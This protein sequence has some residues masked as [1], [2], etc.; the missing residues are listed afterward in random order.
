[1]PN[2]GRV[3]RARSAELTL[4]LWEIKK[5]HPGF[6]VGFDFSSQRSCPVSSRRCTA[7]CTAGPA[8]TQQ[9]CP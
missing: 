5:S 9:P 4:T 7:D 1:M 6:G 8:P 2:S 3:T